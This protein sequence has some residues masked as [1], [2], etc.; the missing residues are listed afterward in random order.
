M[1]IVAVFSG[2]YSAGE[3]IAR[4]VANRLKYDFV[5]E[6][7]FEEAAQSYGT[8]VA[9]LSRAMGKRAF[10][11]SVTHEWERSVV[12]IRAELAK[13]LTKDNL[14]YHGPATHLI[15]STL[16]HALKVGIVAETDFR[17]ARAMDGTGT[18]A[19]EAAQQVEKADLDVAQ[20]VEQLFGRGPWDSS[21]YDVKIPIPA[22]S[23]D[24]AVS[25]I[26]E[27]VAK[28]ALLPTDESNQV[29]QDFAL[30][31]NLNTTLLE[32]GHDYCDA[33]AE[34]GRVT[35]V[36]NKNKSAPGAFI[37]AIQMLRYDQAE[38]EVR[39]ISM[40]FD[41][42]KEVNTLPGVGYKRLSRALLV[43]DEQEYVLTLSQRLETR[44]IDSH[45]VH[46]GEQALDAV[47][48]EVPDVMVLDLKMP[49]IDG[50]EVLRRV[51]REHPDVEVII[52]T[53]HGSEEDE[54]MAKDL[55]AFAFLTKPVDIDVLA[56]TMKQA[57]KKVENKQ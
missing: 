39:K 14:V 53:G 18:N 19:A 56:E 55:G 1:T 49:G 24:D 34:D 35:V 13:R 37:R 3:E 27:N 28:D 38:Q 5:G 48:G 26:C 44:D 43:D 25:M 22:T 33:K 7:L 46:D 57:Y 29:V 45:V 23:V 17:I 50:V 41:G 2:I 21:L 10:F 4:E 32:S 12:Y 40:G 31:A 47:G 54:R 15:P 9:K 11:N 30:A 52:L 6:E 20:W 51:K 42:V 16:S 8:S 36:I